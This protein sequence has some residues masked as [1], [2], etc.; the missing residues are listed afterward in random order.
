MKVKVLVCEVTSLEKEIGNWFKEVGDVT[1]TNVSQVPEPKSK[2]VSLLSKSV[3]IV[4]TICYTD[5]V[6]APVGDPGYGSATQRPATPKVSGYPDCPN[7]KGK[8][9][10]RLRA[11]DQQP[12]WGCESFPK[13]KGII[14]FEEGK[15]LIPQRG[16]IVGSSDDEY[17]GGDY[18]GDDGDEI[19]F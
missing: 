11:R 14:D 3:S 7:C 10:V 15:E 13:C 17:S 18:S 8:M 2:Q 12:F 19:P 5:R 9:V 1:I 6:G 4:T 16:P